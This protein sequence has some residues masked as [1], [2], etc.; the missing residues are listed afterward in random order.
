MPTIQTAG[1]R[2]SYSRHGAGPAVLLIQ[3]VGLV[4]AGWTPQVQGLADRFTLITFDNRGIGAS[5]ITGGELSIEAMAADA[6]AI[7][8]AEKLERFY[9][10]GHSMGGVI[11][12]QVA[13]MAP[14]RVL[15][16]GL[17]CTFAHGK[18][19]TQMTPRL[20]W[21]G[22]RSRIGPRAAR[23][24]AFLEIIMPGPAL[25]RIDR[26]RL[27]EELAPL[28]GHDLAEQPPIVMQQLKA[29]ARYD[30]RPELHRLG[31]IPTLVLSA[32]EDIIARPAYGRELA[33]AIPGARYVEIP[34]AGHGVP[35]QLSAE[36]NSVLADHFLAS[37][38]V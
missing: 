15:S 6:L 12:Q 4:G 26:Q 5:E 10:A 1:A 38:A 17:L 16:L 25:A 8:D 27:A 7:M 36:V 30:P 2:L 21:R 23:R 24:N 9:V 32:A 34:G 33:S 22:L 28:F 29:L 31:G 13:L 11:A 14:Q 3:G 18:Q 20:L 35:I 19:A 37:V